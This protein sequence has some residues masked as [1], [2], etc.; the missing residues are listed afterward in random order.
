MEWGVPVEGLY[1]EQEQRSRCS[2]GMH[3]IIPKKLQ[4]P[5][6]G[7]GREKRLFSSSAVHDPQG[8]VCITFCLSNT[9]LS[10]QSHLGAGASSAAARGRLGSRER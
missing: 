2:P 7:E 5:H 1:Q 4:V 10:L 3:H 8:S 6:S 9:A